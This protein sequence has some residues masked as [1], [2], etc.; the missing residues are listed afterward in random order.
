[1]I[2][3]LREQFPHFS[4]RTLCGWLGVNRQWY[5]QQL[6]QQKRL[7]QEA[8][9]RQQM[10]QVVLT[11]PG[12]G[13]RRV[14]HALKRTGVN[15]NHKR[16]LRIMREQH[17]LCT[18]KRR[19]V[20]TTDSRHRYQRYPNLV[21]NRQ[22]EAPDSCW[23]ADLTYIRLPNEFVY[24]ACLLDSFSLTCVGWSLGRGLDHTLTLEALEMALSRRHVA[25]G[26]IH[27]SD[28]GVQYANSAYVRRLSEVGACI[29]MAA[30]GNPYQNA[31]AESFM[32]TLK[33]E[34]IYL[35]DYR[36]LEEARA[37][38]EHFL[39]QVYNRQRL[40]SALNYRPPEE[41]EQ[42]YAQGLLP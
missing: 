29:S 31:Q 14:T 12:H 10:E 4:V 17:W 33:V 16:V 40:H 21:A 3:Q 13:Y 7:H 26:L 30:T 34:E 20:H 42:L 9:I 11:F 28:Q 27:H 18:P 1:M 35:K 22:F 8:V 32:K 39:M 41:F 36:S 6:K 38:I 15:I 24:L 5:Y 2:S 19:T 23:V 37:N 25:P